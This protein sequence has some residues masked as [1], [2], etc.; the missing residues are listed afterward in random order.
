[1]ILGLSMRGMFGRQASQLFT[2]WCIGWTQALP[3]RGP[4]F[5]ANRGQRQEPDGK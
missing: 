3:A 1:M 4:E 5:D 2:A